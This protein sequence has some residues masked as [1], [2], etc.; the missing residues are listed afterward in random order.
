[1]TRQ[2]ARTPRPHGAPRPP[3][4]GRRPFVRS[5]ALLAASALA[6]AGL[7]T[8][9][10]AAPAT[11]TATAAAP[12]VQSAVVGRPTVP[13]APPAVPGRGRTAVVL[14]QWTW[15]SIARECT[16]TL[17]PAGYAYVQ[18]SPPQEHVRGPQ[19]WT[20]YQP[21]SYRI[22]SKLGTRA[23]YRA[24]V[25]ACNAAGVRVIADAVVNH[26][27][28]QSAGGTGWAGTRFQHYAYPGPEGG[29]GPQDF[30]ACRRDIANYGDRWEVQSCNLV[31]LAD[32]D[33]GSSYVRDEI[34]AYLNDL[35]GLG[36][37]GFR[38]DAA[39]H[40]PA[41]DLAAI[42][43]RLANPNIFWVHE[44]I[45][46]P[47][48]P[49]QPSEYLSS[50]DS[51]EFGYART[52]ASSFDG[53]ISS[54]RTLGSGLLP[55]DRAGVFVDNHD[56][57]RDTHGTMNHTWGAKYRL[58][59]VL[60]LAHPYG[61]PS[62]HSGYRFTDRDAGA[63]QEGDGGVRDAV[64]GTTTGTFT[65]AHR[66]PEIKNMVGFRTSVGD[67]PLTDWWDDGGNQIAFGRGDRGFVVINNGASSMTRT[68]QTS[69]AA[70]S[71]C[72]VVAGDGCTR[73][74]TVDG[75]GRTT[76]TVPAY[77]ALALHVGARAGGGTT[78]PPATST[79]VYYSTTAGWS[80]YNV[81]YRVG[82]GS[83]TAVPGVAMAPACT[84]WVSRT[85]PT[86]GAAVTAAFTDGRG[87]WDN[88]GGRDY[89]LSGATAA[90]RGGTVTT[91]DPCR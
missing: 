77:G 3:V 1:M 41:A 11:A 34:A 36:V 46:S 37:S 29:Y 71:Y 8:A 56:T 54:L 70:G 33:T 32:L 24:M 55:S 19:W 61:W 64:C 45:G 52:L 67:V 2:P 13:T 5:V 60:M 15:N 81:H 22:E 7:A 59:N 57:E 21:V 20:S 89:T 53:R 86:S 10:V 25:Q 73:T 14:F 30:N 88:N 72:D 12:T 9:G 76:V 44:V 51:H 50:G 6:A 49:V 65:C 90:V 62:V 38:I 47:G 78:P 85:I 35:I 91:T 26:M 75:S 74:V 16:S 80:G 48:E 18:T 27:S 66:W 82:S 23:E 79:T 69:L 28:G 68:L 83:W 42:K 43:G 4:T 17:G 58:A 40:M 63:P 31:N 84:G 87:R 39:K